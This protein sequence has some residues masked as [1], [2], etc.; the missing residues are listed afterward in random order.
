[1]RPH[2]NGFWPGPLEGHETAPQDG[3]ILADLFRAQPVTT[4]SASQQYPRREGSPI[5]HGITVPFPIASLAPSPPPKPRSSAADNG[6]W[7]VGAPASVVAAQFIPVAGPSPSAGKPAGEGASAVTY[8]SQVPRAGFLIDRDGPV[9][10]MPIQ[11]QVHQDT[12][13]AYRQRLPEQVSTLEE[14]MQVPPEDEQE[15]EGAEPAVLKGYNPNAWSPPLRYGDTIV[16]LVEGYNAMVA[17]GSSSDGRAWIQFLRVCFSFTPPS[18]TL[19]RAYVRNSFM[20]MFAAEAVET[21]WSLNVPAQC[22]LLNWR[23][24]EGRGHVPP[25]SNVH[26][27]EAVET[28]WSLNVPA[29]LWRSQ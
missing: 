3:D 20:T 13:P 8:T 23:A 17:Y 9:V 11:H 25:L 14:S 22:P 26:W 6:H 1:M 24:K 4:Y 7:S 21:L 16:L 28:L 10:G 2:A 27:T 5:P 15:W 29:L 19:V 12:F 18:D